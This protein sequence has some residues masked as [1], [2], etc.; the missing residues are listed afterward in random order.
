[1]DRICIEGFPRSGNIFC[2]EL[3]IKAFPEIYIK[4]FN[5]SANSLTEEHFVLIRDPNVAISSFMSVFK[6]SN[7]ETSEA[8]W[9]RFHNVMLDKVSPDRWIFFDEL[10]KDTDKVINYIGQILK[11]KP[12][13]IDHTKLNKNSSFQSYEIHLFNKA[14]EFYCNLKQKAGK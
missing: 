4:P 3:L 10:V 7:K 9:L 6:E 2:Q 8:W 13:L 5:H 11:I 1:M 14:E 12:V